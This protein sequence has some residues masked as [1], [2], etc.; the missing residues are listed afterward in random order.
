MTLESMVGRA[1]KASLFEYYRGI[2]SAATW[3]EV[4]AA[5]FGIA[6]TDFLDA[7]EAYRGDVAPA[8]AR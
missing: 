1:G 7:F 6:V 3:E 5:V 4:F 8:A 2:A